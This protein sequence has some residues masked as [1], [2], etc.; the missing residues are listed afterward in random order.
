MERNASSQR[1]LWKMPFAL[2]RSQQ[3]DIEPPRKHEGK[4]QEVCNLIFKGTAK[5]PRGQTP[6]RSTFAVAQERL[7]KLA[8]L[9][10]G[11]QDEPIVGGLDI[12]RGSVAVAGLGDPI[13]EEQNIHLTPPPWP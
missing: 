4:A 8:C 11:L 2:K 13:A 1:A 12:Q 3:I 5:L 7:N 10:Q 6:R 9:L